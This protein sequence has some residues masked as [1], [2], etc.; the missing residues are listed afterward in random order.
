VTRDRDLLTNFGFHDDSFLKDTI[1]PE[2]WQFWNSM[3][4]YGLTN[5]W[6]SRPIGGEIYP[7]LQKRLW[8]SRPNN[9]GQNVAVAI[10]AVH[11][12]W[13]LDNR[14]FEKSPAKEERTN[15]LRA[16]RML[17][18]TLFCSAARL[19]RASDG[20]AMI[21]ARMENRG[22][23]PFYASWPVEL[24]ALD[25]EGKVVGRG[26]AN[27]PLATLLPGQTSEWN[28]RLEAL[29][30]GVREIVIR[31]ANPMP[32]GHPVVFANEE[33]GTLKSGWLTLGAFD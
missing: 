5:S 29:P 30:E 23:A 7:Q 10:S 14:L 24:A 2:E 4:A 26:Q 19:A 18:Y 21:S 33:M 16:E 1:G 15:A 8:D 13:M 17:G 27:W 32:N 3:Q 22:V 25:S 12:T 9:D 31:I 20:S 11:A 6:E 28:A